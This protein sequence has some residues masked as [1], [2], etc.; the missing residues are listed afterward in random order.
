MYV[1]FSAG[2]K[3]YKLR[4]STRAIVQLEKNIACNPLS[5]FGRGDTIP[6][7]TTMV[8]VLHAALQ[9]FNHGI[10]LDDAYGIFDNWI[11]DGHTVT[12]FIPVIVDIY[13]T[14]GLIPEDVE[15]KN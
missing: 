8:Y 9:Q 11:A 15:E 12:E 5:I 13:K 1:D 3:D 14:S 10:T 4:L 6:A 2:N 7:V